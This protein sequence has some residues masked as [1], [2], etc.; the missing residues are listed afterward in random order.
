MYA[1]SSSFTKLAGALALTAVALCGSAFA[2]DDAKPFLGGWD[3]TIPGG[4]AG[5]LGVEEKDG[6]LTADILWG[7]GSVVPVEGVKVEGDK[8][9]IDRATRRAIRKRSPPE[10]TATK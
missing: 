3:L 2:A 5:W 1:R 7:G 8:L 9:S 10:S 4:G 6:Q